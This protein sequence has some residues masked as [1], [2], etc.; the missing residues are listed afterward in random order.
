MGCLSS[1]P[2][3]NSKS[4][5]QEKYVEDDQKDFKKEMMDKIKELTLQGKH[6]D[7]LENL[8]SVCD[9][10]IGTNIKETDFVYERYIDVA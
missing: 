5:K 1:K 8:L 10:D 3:E 4:S 7:A 6:E 2:K 9:Y